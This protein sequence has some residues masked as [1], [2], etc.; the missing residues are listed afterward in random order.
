M[1]KMLLAATVAAL[2]CGS[3][4]HPAAVQAATMQPVLDDA[5][6]AKVVQVAKQALAE[7]HAKGCIVITDADGMTIFFQRMAGAYTNCNAAATV[8]AKSAAQFQLPT[9][10]LYA[11]LDKQNQL[12]ILAVPDMSPLPGGMPLKVNGVVVG[13]LGIST[14]DGNVDTPVVKLAAAAL[15]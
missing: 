13:G 12:H 1:K 2:A 6:V 15:H 14:P 10:D 7:R 8:K 11:Q 9:D 5:D 4:F 3:V